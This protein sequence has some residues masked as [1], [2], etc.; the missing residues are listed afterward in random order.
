MGILGEVLLAVTVALSAL[1]VILNAGLKSY[2]ENKAKNLATKEDL[3][4]LILE[5][6]EKAIASKEGEITGIQNKLD[7]VVEQN[8]RLVRSS[9]E[10]KTDVSEK[11]SSRQRLRDMRREVAFKLMNLF[12][13]LEEILVSATSEARRLHVLPLIEDHHLKELNE[14]YER[15]LKTLGQIAKVKGQVALVFDDP[16]REL[17]LA[18]DSAAGGVIQGTNHFHYNDT[19]SAQLMSIYNERYVRFHTL[20]REQML[21]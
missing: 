2:I 20:I 12:G 3:K 5:V 4:H 7:I 15:Y 9:E 19:K 13:T 16:A 8:E 10:I 18:V 17:L 1:A 6:R 14:I 21:A 11:S